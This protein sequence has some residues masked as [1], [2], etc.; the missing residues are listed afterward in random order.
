MKKI[1]PTATFSERND[2]E[3][4]QDTFAEALEVLDTRF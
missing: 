1:L 4:V 2:K 3:H